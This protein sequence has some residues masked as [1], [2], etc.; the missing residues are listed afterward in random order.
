MVKHGLTPLRRAAEPLD[1]P[2]W[3]TTLGPVGEAL[4]TW[5]AEIIESLGG[6]EHISA[7]ER[8]VI[9]TATKTYLILESVDRWCLLQPSLVNKQKHQLFPSSCSGRR[10][11]TR[12]SARSPRW[13]SNVGGLLLSIS[14]DPSSRP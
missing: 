4:R 13:A 10:S 11:R 5:R 7:Q 2:D 9:E 12:S 6:E 3:L 8:A 1:D 14:R